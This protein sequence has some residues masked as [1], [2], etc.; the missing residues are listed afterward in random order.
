MSENLGDLIE[1]DD[2]SP[3]IVAFILKCLHRDIRRVQLFFLADVLA[4]PSH[5]PVS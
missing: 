3:S 4:P 5:S 2:E 1:D